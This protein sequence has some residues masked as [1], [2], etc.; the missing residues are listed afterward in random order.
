MSRPR[1]KR[2]RPRKK[3]DERA[4]LKHAAM[5]YTMKE[6][7]AL[8][9]VSEDTLTRNFADAI[10]RGHSLRNARLRRRQFQLALK[11]NPQMLIWL[12]KQFLAQRDKQEVVTMNDPLQELLDEFKAQR[13]QT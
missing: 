3:I 1:K 2:G 5:G 9:G 8:T 4:L 6:L 12:G 7:E 10:E 11:G 13:A